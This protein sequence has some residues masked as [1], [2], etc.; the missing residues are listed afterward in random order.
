LKLLFRKSKEMPG[1]LDLNAL[2]AMLSGVELGGFA[3]AAQRLNRSQSAVSMQLRKLEKQ[4]GQQLFKRDGRSLAL[5]DAGEV[6]LK[7]AR[8][9]LALNDEAMAALGVS[10]VGGTIRVGMPQD[11]VDVLLPSLLTRFTKVRPGMHIEVRAGRNYALAEDVAAG[12]LDLALAFA[13]PGRNKRERV[14]TLPRVWVANAPGPAKALEKLP[15]PLVVFDGPCLFRQSGIAALDRAGIPW[16]LALTTPSLSGVWVGV[17]ASLGITVRTPVAVPSYLSVLKAGAVLP[18]LPA[19]DLLLHT[20]N[21]PTLAVKLLRDI[22]HETISGECRE[23]IRGKR[24]A[25]AHG[26][27]RAAARYRAA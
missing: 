3:H 23:L 16:R 11:F 21:E 8:R 7:Y 20:S 2:R 10:A 24:V 12:R 27:G 26:T 17:R 5:T 22:L 4:A 14:A 18:K 25:I 6:L 19:V 13:E 9:L 15:M 1:N